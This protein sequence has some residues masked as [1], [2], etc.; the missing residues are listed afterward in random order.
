MKIVGTGIDLVEV[1]RFHQAV[2][3]WGDR[4]LGRLF[5]ESE[6]RYA[7]AHRTM[8]QHLA[9]RF[10]AKEAVVK[11]LGAPK[12]LA[13]EWKDL[14]IVRSKSGQPSVRLAGTMKRWSRLKIHVS[15]T[16]THAYAMATAVVVSP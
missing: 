7:R 4:L 10:A 6:L 13:L 1:P 15:L 9:A 14:E 16:H 12:G 8:A 5:T 3:R 2:Q 11:A